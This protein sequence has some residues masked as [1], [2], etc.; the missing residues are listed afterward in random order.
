MADDIGEA[1]RVEVLGAQHDR[2]AFESGVE[3][4]DR[5][6]RVQAGQDARRNM[7]APFVLVLSDGAVAAEAADKKVVVAYQTDA[8]PSSVA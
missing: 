5:Y 4:L 7:A 3:P 8:L 1:P 6:F 2:S